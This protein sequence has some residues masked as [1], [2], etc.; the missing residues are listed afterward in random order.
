MLLNNVT[1]VNERRPGNILIS[2][3]I[4]AETG[5]RTPPRD[6]VAIH[7]SDAIAFPGLIN[8]HDH[9]DFNCFSPLGQRT[10]KN[11][12]EWGNHI[13]ATYKDDINAVLKI[14]QSLRTSWGIYKNLLAG[15]TTVLNHG[16]VLK[17][18]NPLIHVYQAP[19]N[20]HSVKFQKNWRWKLNNPLLKNRACIIHTGEGVDEQSASEISALL[21]WNLLNRKLIGVHGVAM[22]ALQAKKFAG[23]VWCPESNALLLNRH[24]AIAAL[25]VN[26]RLVFGT[27][28]T[29]TGNWNMWH[30]LR[31]ARALRVITDAE[32]YSTVTG[33]PAELWGFNTG[34]V[35]PGR[36]ADI[37]IA[38]TKNGLAAWNDFFSLD[39]VDILMVLQ[40]GRIRMFDETLLPQ[41]NRLKV[42]TS[43][44]S[45]VSIKGSV[46][47][48]EGD[49]PALVLA[50]RKYNP[51]IGFPF[52]TPLNQYSGSH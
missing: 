20:L 35:Q 47:F 36:D 8:S 1:L 24:A 25:K 31:V 9:L 14:P 30:H 48:V 32:L 29:L 16:P 19:Q 7:F 21:K 46:K 6:A 44:F 10:Y 28:S 23:L 33:S 39:P 42:D 22:N 51:A 45:A 50:I 43:G 15:V 5:Q 34:Y 49:L 2:H 26:T 38:K 11:Y 18:E 41:L 3:G 13:H 12:T 37:V 4:I 17:I 27:D 52:S 40:K